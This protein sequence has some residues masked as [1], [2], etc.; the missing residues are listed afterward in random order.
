MSAPGV[1]VLTYH[2]QNI[3]GNEY[4][5]NDHVSL[6]HDLTL[7]ADLGLKVR[8]LDDVIEALFYDGDPAVLDRA[9][10]IT[11][12]D[13]TLFDVADL[14][15]PEHGRQK[16]MMRILSDFAHANPG[17]DWAPHATAFVIASPRVRATLE[18][19]DLF[20]H[21]WLGDD[22]WHEADAS[23]FMTI[24]N[25]SWDHRHPALI[26]PDEGGGDFA[27]VDTEPACREQIVDAGRFIAERIGRWPSLF[28][29]P[30][31]HASDYLRNEY[32]PNHTR[33]HQTQAA[34]STE[35]GYIDTHS[36]PW[37]LPRFICGHHWKH[38]HELAEILDR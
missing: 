21:P 15:H 12:D 35:A 33:Q 6:E 37:F 29:Y 3:F 26:P 1:A 18:Q 7:I 31:G 34:F 5:I 22:W 30:F 36:V 11:F 20:G 19:S 24:G 16:S 14:D 25:H 28:A 4:G 2:S 8:P 38:E 13:G 23:E 9:V 32:F 27:S 10:C 17:L